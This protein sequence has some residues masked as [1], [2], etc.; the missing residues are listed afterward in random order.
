[1]N[2]LPYVALS[3]GAVILGPRFEASVPVRAYYLRKR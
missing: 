2:G 1:M 3:S